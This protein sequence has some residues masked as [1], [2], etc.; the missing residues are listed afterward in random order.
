MKYILFNQSFVYVK[1]IDDYIRLSGFGEYHHKKIVN[2]I[3]KYDLNFYLSEQKA[4]SSEPDLYESIE[5]CKVYP[6]TNLINERLPISFVCK[7]VIKALIH[8]FFRFVGNIQLLFINK[9]KFHVVRKSYV[10]DVEML[11]HDDDKVIRFVYPFPLNLRRQLSY[12]KYLKKNDLKYVLAGLPYRI[13]DLYFLLKFKKYNNYLRMENRAQ[14]LHAYE[15]QKLKNVKVVQC[16]EEY[17]IGSLIYAKMVNRL[18]MTIM[19]RAHG[20]GKYLPYHSYTSFDVL[21]DSQAIYYNYFNKTNHE[22]IAINANIQQVKKI[23]DEIVLCF[24]GQYSE[25]SPKIIYED[26]IDILNIISKVAA[27]YNTVNYLYKKHPNCRSINIEEFSGI[28]ILDGKVVAGDPSLILQISLYST[29]QIDPNF[30]G[31]KVLIETQYIKP[32]LLYG[33]AQPVVNIDELHVFL[34]EWIKGKLS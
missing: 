22:I 33:E 27:N 21:T 8:L 1:K 18:G 17:E 19:N 32:R 20:V 24:L 11:F 2:F 28:D 5:T 12:L 4:F 9:K 25:S 3:Y 14:I 6:N 29:C 31:D 16:A 7:A 15:L 30:I 13:R 10:D 23:P 26:E 34:E